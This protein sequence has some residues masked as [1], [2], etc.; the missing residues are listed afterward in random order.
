M[1]A[2]KFPRTRMFWM[3]AG[4][5][6]VILLIGGGFAF[7]W[8]GSTQ[9]AAA[10]FSDF[11]KAAQAGTVTV[12]P[13]IHWARATVARDGA[14]WKVTSVRWMYGDDKPHEPW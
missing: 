11:L 3:G 13:T 4:A 10:P 6:L 7:K 8:N 9:P 1:R 12:D 5:L 14:T 2:G